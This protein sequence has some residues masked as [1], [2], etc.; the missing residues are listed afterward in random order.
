[1]IFNFISEA[2]T[3]YEALFMLLFVACFGGVFVS[4]GIALTLSG[5][6]MSKRNSRQGR[7]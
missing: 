1:M 6:N 5:W 3:A 2:G 4:L 7:Q